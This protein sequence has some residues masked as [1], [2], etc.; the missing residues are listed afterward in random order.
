MI[1]RNN[2]EFGYFFNAGLD[3]FTGEVDVEGTDVFEKG[4]YIGS[5]KY[6]MP[7][8][9]AV[10]DDDELEELLAENGIILNC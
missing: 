5:I 10:M 9:I 4:H 7:E 1:D 3:R 2:L 6:Q 8:D